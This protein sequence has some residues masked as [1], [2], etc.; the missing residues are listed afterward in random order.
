MSSAQRIFSPIYTH[1]DNDNPSRALKECEQVLKKITKKGAIDKDGEVWLT[2]NVLKAIAFQRLN[3][4]EEALQAAAIVCEAQPSDE[5]ILQE[6]FLSFLIL[7]KY[8][9]E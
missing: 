6:Q 5:T 1:L 7:Y 9:S 2:T 4:V 8:N 3:R